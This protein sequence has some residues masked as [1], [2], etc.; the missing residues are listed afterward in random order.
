MSDKVNHNVESRGMY[1]KVGTLFGIEVWQDLRISQPMIV[2]RP[3]DIQKIKNLEQVE[4]WLND[5][6]VAEAKEKDSE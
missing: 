3:Q 6:K 2:I 5:N 4:K 1:Q